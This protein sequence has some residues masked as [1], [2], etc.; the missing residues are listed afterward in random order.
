MT[1]TKS[2]TASPLNEDALVDILEKQDA[3]KAAKMEI[4][5]VRLLLRS[6]KPLDTDPELL[7]SICEHLDRTTKQFKEESILV[8]DYMTSLS[9]L[10]HADEAKRALDKAGRAFKEVRVEYEAMKRDLGKRYDIAK[11][12]VSRARRDHDQVFTHPTERIRH[13]RDRY[14]DLIMRLHAELDAKEIS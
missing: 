1:I 4:A 11:G 12:V 10:E 2:A 7:R 13:L 6:G 3:E 14:P 5:W 9:K 8:G